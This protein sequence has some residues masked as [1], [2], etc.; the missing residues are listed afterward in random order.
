MH[1]KLVALAATAALAGCPALVLA[2]FKDWPSYNNTL[3]SER[4]ATLDAIDSK[5]VAGLKVLCSFD[6]GEQVSFQTGLL[7]A[8]G[9]LLATTEH[10][11][12]SIDANTCKQNWRAH[13]E[14]ASGVLKVNR[15]AG[16]ARR[17]GISRN[18]RRP[19]HR[20]HREEWQAA[21][22]D[23]HC[24]S[25]EGRVGAGGAD[26]LERHGIRRQCRRRQQGSQG[27]YVRPRRQGR[28]VSCG[29]FT[30]CRRRRTTWCVERRRPVCPPKPRRRGRTPRASR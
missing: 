14:F 19:G 17:P 1:N 25:C 5:N 3:T 22:V 8:D 20:L 23:R 26:R 9:A 21:V 24:R 30:W 12:I 27:A 7:E 28:E 6:T 16:M 10:D 15:G 11:T 13:A 4:Y 18:G 29:S 2:A